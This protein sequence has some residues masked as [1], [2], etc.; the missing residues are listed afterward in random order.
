MPHF[1]IGCSENIIKIKSP[2]E[3]IQ[4]C[5]IQRNQLTFLIKEILK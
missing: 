1:V 2:K 4:K 5:M 3:I